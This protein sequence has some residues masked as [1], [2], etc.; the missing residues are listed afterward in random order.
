MTTIALKKLLIN[1]I[2]EIND[3]S[4]LNA[5]KTILDTK[6]QAHT[7]SLTPGQRFEIIESQKEIESGLLVEQVELDKGFNIRLSGK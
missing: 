2:A 5:L 3:V 4:F 1:R 6:T 7:L